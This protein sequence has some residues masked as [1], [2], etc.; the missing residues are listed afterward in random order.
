M[1]SLMTQ[2]VFIFYQIKVATAPLDSEVVA[3]LLLNRILNVASTLPLFST[4]NTF[5]PA[6]VV[7]AT[8]C[9]FPTILLPI[10]TEPGGTNFE[11]WAMI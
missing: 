5:F 1:Q 10:R 9:K 6:G 11:A 3:H 7:N 8:F 2:N 4:I